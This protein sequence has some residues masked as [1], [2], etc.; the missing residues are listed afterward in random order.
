MRNASGAK[1]TDALVKGESSRMI[2]VSM[3]VESFSESDPVD[4]TIHT[5]SLVAERTLSAFCGTILDGDSLGGS[6]TTRLP[7]GKTTR[8]GIWTT[9]PV[10]FS[11]RIG[12]D[13]LRLP[14]PPRLGVPPAITTNPESH[15]VRLGNATATPVLPTRVMVSDRH[16]ESVGTGGVASG[17]F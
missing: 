6:T 8:V 17:G 14:G 5:H 13:T 15:D 2:N 3:A 10:L 1:V 12:I 4:P 16:A 7:G 11:N 9:Y